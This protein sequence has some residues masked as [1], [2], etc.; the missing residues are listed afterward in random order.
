M[1]S[2]ISGLFRIKAWLVRHVSLTSH[3]APPPPNP[4]VFEQTWTQKLE[5]SHVVLDSLPHQTFTMC[6]CCCYGNSCK[7]FCPASRGL[8]VTS[9]RSSLLKII[10]YLNKVWYTAVLCWGLVCM[11]SHTHVHNQAP[12]CSVV[13]T[14]DAWFCWLLISYR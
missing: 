11:T 10:R 6:T 3:M 14:L 13:M 12:P 1:T 8:T 9:E 4:L 5:M 7:H 2:H